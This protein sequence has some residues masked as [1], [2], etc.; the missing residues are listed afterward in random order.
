MGPD[1]LVVWMD[2][3]NS[4]VRPH[5]HLDLSHT[6]SEAFT[7]QFSDQQQHQQE[8]DT[9]EH[10]LGAAKNVGS[11]QQQTAN[12]RSRLGHDSY[13]KSSQKSSPSQNLELTKL[14]QLQ[15][16][17]QSVV[18]PAVAAA[19]AKVSDRFMESLGH[20]VYGILVYGLPSLITICW[21]ILFMSF[22][23]E[24]CHECQT[25]PPPNVEMLQPRLSGL[26]KLGSV[27]MNES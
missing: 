16:Q 26:R 22:V 9:L 27:D 4:W 5:D 20:F 11:F 23:C 21:I 10:A 6:D 14:S 8:I 24:S 17:C 2:M 12:S 13:Q 19:A 7:G 1:A 15:V 18:P 3:W 25:D